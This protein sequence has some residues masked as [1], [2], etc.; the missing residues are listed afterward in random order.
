MTGVTIKIPT[1]NILIYVSLIWSIYLLDMTRKLNVHSL[2]V[3]F[4]ISTPLD[5]VYMDHWVM[6]I[7]SG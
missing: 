3:I 1:I 6:Y 2:Y 4:R 5:E 7:Y